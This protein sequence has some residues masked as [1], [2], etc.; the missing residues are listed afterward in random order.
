MTPHIKAKKDEIAKVVLMP[1]DPLRAKFIA[2]NFL[3]DYKCVNDVRGMLAFTGF[4][5]NKKITVMG[6][7]M[8]IPSIGIYSHELFKFYDVD[9]IIRIGSCGSYIKGME[10]GQIIIGNQAISNSTYAKSIGVNTIEDTLSA[11][12]ELVDLANSTAKELGIKTINGLI[13]SSDV[14]YS[15]NVEYNNWVNSLIDNKNLLAAEMEA[16]GLYAN[17]IKNNKKALTIVSVSD[18]I[19][20]QNKCLSPDERVTTFKNMMSLALEM[21]IKIA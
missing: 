17:A 5:K 11:T 8:G 7:G 19:V 2:E 16:F 13:L 1:G 3:T 9:T 14:F 6:H 4:Y 21:A 12:K 18:S 20:E 10:L 15:E